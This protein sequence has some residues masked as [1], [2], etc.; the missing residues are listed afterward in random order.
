VASS[1]EPAAALRRAL[2]PLIADPAGTVLLFDFDGTLSPIVDR[3]EDAR[4]ADGVVERLGRLAER[5]RRVGVVSGRPVAFLAE[6]L[7]ASLYLSG[8]YGME[9]LADGVRADLPEVEQWRGVM[10][11]AVARARAGVPVGARVEPKGLSLTIHFR[12]RPDLADEV[13]TLVQ[14]ISRVTGLVHHEAKMSAELL[15]PIDTT[16]ADVVR[17]LAGG[18][19]AVLFVGDDRGDLA[20]LEALPSLAADGVTTVGLAVDT[21]ELPDEV[22]AAADLT[23]VGARAVPDLLLALLGGSGS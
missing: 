23:L 21:P 2:A 22:R 3:P 12:G 4:P 6:H 1:G 17:A 8:Q 10:D 9:S 18:A 7:P 15:P 16:K 13:T 11:D 5:Y 14:D 20:A 19:R